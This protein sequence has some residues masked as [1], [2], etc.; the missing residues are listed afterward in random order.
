M[1]RLRLWLVPL[2]VVALLA[3]IL[4]AAAAG[5]GSRPVAPAPEGVA[6]NVIL[7]IGDGMG[8][9]HRQA[10]AFQAY[11]IDGLLAMDRMPALGLSET[12]S[13]DNMITDSGAGA[14]AIASGVKTYNG[15]IGVDPEGNPVVTILELAQQA[16][17]ATGLIT[18]TQ[19]SHA[20]PAA[21][22]A[23]VPD[24]GMMDEIASQ[25]L[26]HRVTVLL[27][28]GESQFLP[29]EVIGHYPQPGDR[30]DGRDLT[31]EAQA[32]GYV[33]T[34][35]EATLKAVNTVTTRRLLGLFGDQ[36]MKRPHSPSLALMTQKAIEVLS[37]DRDGFF[38]MVE[39]GQIDWAAHGNDAVNAIGDTLALDEAVKV[40]LKF[41]QEFKQ[42]LVIVTADHETGGMA[43]TEVG[44]GDGPFYT[45]DGR[46][47]YIDWA[48]TWHT[49]IEV[50]TTAW[51][52]A[53]WRVRGHFPNT[54]LFTA[55]A[56][57]MHLSPVPAA[58][59][60]QKPAARPALALPEVRRH[61]PIEPEASPP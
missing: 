43:I 57:A 22:A 55:M 32:A 21:F 14:T 39:G 37:R 28:G 58:A 15:A 20:T 51:G 30:T 35:D 34:W 38:L 60:H 56:D 4:V 44:A 19:I 9:A 47:F 23:H 31:A 25:L 10:A 24:R 13:S 8:H 2:L 18:T 42:T 59:S 49:G 17:K 1:S 41:A 46:V 26:E 6:K 3:N 36:G 45:P 54:Y 12:S 53:S 52:V 48:S 27:G 11:G 61:Y 29:V 7:F 16:G 5:Q 33:Y 40:G 50:T